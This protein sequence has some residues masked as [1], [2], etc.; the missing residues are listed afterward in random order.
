M[1][2][3]I[4]KQKSIK[5]NA[6]KAWFHNYYQFKDVRDRLNINSNFRVWPAVH[7]IFRNYKPEVIYSKGPY[8]FNLIG[9]IERSPNLKLTDAILYSLDLPDLMF[10]EFDKIFEKYDNITFA[11]W[12][13]EK[14]VAQDILD[15]IMKPGLAVT[16]NDRDIFSA[17]EMLMFMQLY[18]LSNSESDH[19]E[20]AITDHYNAVLKPWSEYLQKKGVKYKTEIQ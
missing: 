11:E 9:L 1:K 13:E 2:F 8:P 3:S 20:M 10:Y 15:I 5:L 6:F 19:R 7:F 4:I 12:A 18:F 16:L 17:A 14:K